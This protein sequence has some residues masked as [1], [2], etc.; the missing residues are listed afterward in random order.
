MKNSKSSSEFVMKNMRVNEIVSS[1]LRK[2]YD[3]SPLTESQ[4]IKIH[5]QQSEP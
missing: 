1:S 4:D 2:D 3:K 5:H